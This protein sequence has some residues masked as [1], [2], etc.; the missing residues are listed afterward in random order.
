MA[1]RVDTIV[2]ET[3]GKLPE[4][5]IDAHLKKEGV[6]GLKVRSMALGNM[7]KQ[8]EKLDSLFEEFIEDLPEEMVSK[9]ECI[10]NELNME[11]FKH[12]N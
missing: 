10:Q 4:W 1:K 7:L 11:I 6:D 8:L 12:G 5:I 2:I 3:E 9:Y